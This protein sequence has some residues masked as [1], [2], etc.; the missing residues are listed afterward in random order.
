MRGLLICFAAKLAICTKASTN[1]SIWQVPDF[2][3]LIFKNA[4]MLIKICSYG[5]AAS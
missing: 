2:I 1:I 4:I 3:N 5:K